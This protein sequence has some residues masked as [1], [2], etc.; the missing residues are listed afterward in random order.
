MVDP[1]GPTPTANRTRK[2][3]TKKKYPNRRW[4]RVKFLL[5]L[6]FI[7]GLGF[8]VLSGDVTNPH[9]RVLKHYFDDVFFQRGPAADIQDV[10]DA[11]GLP[12]AIARPREHSRAVVSILAATLW[13][14]RVV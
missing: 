2:K 13:V 14:W 7:V 6:A 10:I 8:F 11:L 9:L 4:G 1:R 3:K 12:I 5:I